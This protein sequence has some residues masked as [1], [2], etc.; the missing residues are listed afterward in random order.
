MLLATALAQQ[1]D[2]PQRRQKRCSRAES[3]HGTKSA[4]FA[5]ELGV[6]RAWRLAAVRDEHGAVAAARDAAR[7]AERG[8]Q[9]A[10]ALRAWYEAVR[11]GD[12]R[13]V[14]PLARLCAEIDCAVGISPSPM[15]GRWPPATRRRCGRCPTSWPRSACARP[16]PTPPRRRS[17]ARSVAQ[18]SRYRDPSSTRSWRRPGTPCHRRRCTIRAGPRTGRRRR[19]VGCARRFRTTWS[20]G[21]CAWL[22]GWGH[23]PEASRRSSGRAPAQPGGIDV[24]VSGPGCGPHLP[25][26]GGVQIPCG[27]KMLGYQGGVFLR[28]RGSRDSRVLATRRCSSVRSDFSCD[29]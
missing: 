6:A 9:P 1:G 15:R 16:P 5:P 27:L 18:P 11:L 13:A 25:A 28:G 12:I 21:R 2:I 3:R 10:A 14:D 22:R 4:L 24:A 23:R 7:M 26:V 19:R 29:S 8:G 17:G 20:G